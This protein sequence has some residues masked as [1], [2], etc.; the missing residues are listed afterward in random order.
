M[1]LF[2][3]HCSLLN[4]LAQQQALHVQSSQQALCIQLWTIEGEALRAS[5]GGTQLW[6]LSCPRLGLRIFRS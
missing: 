4:A 5:S 1:M 6:V 2:N 3:R